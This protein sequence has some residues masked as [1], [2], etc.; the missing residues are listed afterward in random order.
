MEAEVRV[1]FVLAVSVCATALLV[2]HGSAQASGGAWFLTLE[3]G[4]GRSNLSYQAIGRSV[5]LDP[6]TV[7]RESIAITRIYGDGVVGSIEVSWVERGATDRIRTV[8]RPNDGRILSFERSYVDIGVPVSYR[9]GHGRGYAGLGLSPRLSF[10]AVAEDPFSLGMYDRRPLVGLDPS[11]TAGYRSVHLTTRYLVDLT[12]PRD[13][14]YSS[15]GVKITDKVFFIGL[16]C[17][18][19]L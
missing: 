8:F 4:L 12:S 14:S 6:R 7:L 3:S 15:S 9:V 1:R 10:L 17:D 2:A 11:I 13:T 19:A 16:G 5:D 18:I